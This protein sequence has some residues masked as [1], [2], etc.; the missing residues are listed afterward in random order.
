VIGSESF[1]FLNPRECYFSRLRQL[2]ACF[3]HVSSPS[4]KDCFPFLMQQRFY[5]FPPYYSTLRRYW[6]SVSAPGPP[7]L[8][9]CLKARLP[10]IPAICTTLRVGSD[11]FLPASS[12]SPFV[13]PPCLLLRR[14]SFPFFLEL[15]DTPL[16]PLPNHAFYKPLAISYRFSF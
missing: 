4:L 3:L 8:F 6:I 5:F 9:G 15:I 2:F 13:F 12:R 7:S 14:P 16:A 11:S 10:S 1:S